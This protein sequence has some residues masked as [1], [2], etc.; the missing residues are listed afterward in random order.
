MFSSRSCALRNAAVQR[1]N[2]YLIS[3]RPVSGTLH[4]P[5]YINARPEIPVYDTLNISLRG[6]DFAVLE[7]FAKYVHS[8]AEKFNLGCTAF[9]V[10]ARTSTVRSYR[11]H[12]TQP[13]HEYNLAKYERVVE[14]ED[15]LSTTAPILIQLLQANMPAGVEMSIKPVDEDEE[16]FRYVPDLTLLELQAQMAELDKVKEDRKK[17]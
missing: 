1:C 15:L 16:Q 3:K 7:S 13:E 5:D 17:K 6:Y 11:A 14:V 9:A 4:E 8:A 10:P 2:T 12:T